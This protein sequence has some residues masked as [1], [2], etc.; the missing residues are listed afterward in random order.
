[1][2]KTTIIILVILPIILVISISFAARIL[3]IYQHISVEKVRFVDEFNIDYEDGFI[4]R[5]E[6]G[7]EKQLY[8][9]V[10]PD[11]ATNKKVE[12][13]ST[14]S[15]VCSIDQ[16]GVI[17]G[18]SF[19]S[20]IVVVKTEENSMYAQLIISVTQNKVSG[21]NLSFDEVEL[22]VGEST[23]LIAFIEPY[24]AVNKNVVY[25]SSNSLVA[26]IDENGNVKALSEGQTV[27]T[28]ITDD[29]GF[30]D[31]CLVIC[32]L[33]VPAMEFD[34][35]SNENFVKTENGY[36]T[37]L[38]NIQEI[39]LLNYLQINDKQVIIE[40]I[41]FKRPTGSDISQ[42]DKNSGKLI[43]TGKGIISIIAYVGDENTPTYKAELRIMV[44]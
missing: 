12:F 5:I 19:G 34:L 38:A 14:N 20:C 41:R 23:Q 39:N 6:V 11:L 42:I 8:V 35:S 18:V 9:R 7:E 4:Y 29:G 21:V 30:T 28:V 40:N 44:Q 43:I 33:G 26:T 1:M 22:N 32:K 10:Y 27:I 2:K 15:D 31:T 3:S 24:S 36:I 13:S 16:N 37:Q 25:T 17:K